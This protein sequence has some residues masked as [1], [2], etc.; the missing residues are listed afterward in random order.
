MKRGLLIIIS[1]PSGVGKGTIREYFMK[2]EGLNLTY[3]ISM[4][5]RSPRKNEIDGKDYIF[6]TK[7]RFE[8]AI[9]EGD[10]LEW[11]EFVGNYYGTPL[12]QIE[13]LRKEGKNVLLEIEVQ[14]ATQVREKC[15]DAVSI[16]IIPPSMEELEKR[17]RGRRSE[18][19]EVVQQR[20]A[21]AVREMK[22]V[23][24]YKYVVCNDDP[25]L[26]ADMI[27]L[28]IRR[29]MEQEQEEE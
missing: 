1:G 17:I 3:S 23:K 16:F 29:H 9:R 4:T 8:E 13:R 10:L 6:T 5:T 27:T 15:P 24:D 12:S 14:G 19:E 11:A 2:D 28:I 18:P 20:L 26:A 7:E 21:K 25:Q 22:M